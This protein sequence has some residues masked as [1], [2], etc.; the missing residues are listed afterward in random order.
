MRT[1]FSYQC[2]ACNFSLSLAHG[3]GRIAVVQHTGAAH[4][5]ELTQAHTDS[6]QQWFD[7]G[8]DEP[9]IVVRRY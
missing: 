1:G 6:V 4:E 9:P 5:H 7:R 2:M 8:E 3:S